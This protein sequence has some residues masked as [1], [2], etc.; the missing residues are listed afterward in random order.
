VSFGKLCIYW[1]LKSS[2]KVEMPETS[3]CLSSQ[4]PGPQNPK[5][6]ISWG[7]GPPRL[8]Q[9]GQV[10]LRSAGPEGFF[11]ENDCQ[12]N[13]V[14]N[15]KCFIFTATSTKHFGNLQN[16]GKCLRIS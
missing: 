7:A 2:E 8:T 9:R 10:A 3:G 13:P 4:M 16:L 14:K 6:Q 11:R 12:R 15:K 5:K 1:L